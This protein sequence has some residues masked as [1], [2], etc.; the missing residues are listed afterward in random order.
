MFS[1]NLHAFGSGVLREDRRRKTYRGY[2]GLSDA[3][4]TQLTQLSYYGRTAIEA[5]KN[6][7]CTDS[8]ERGSVIRA[9]VASV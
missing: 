6:T 2:F 3:I 4:S 7:I 1:F 8:I 9:I 5:Q